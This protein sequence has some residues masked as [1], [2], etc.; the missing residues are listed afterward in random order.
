M[1]RFYKLLGFSGAA[2]I[3][4][5]VV[6]LFGYSPLPAAAGIASGLVAIG[7]FFA[8]IDQTMNE[9]HGLTSR[10]LMKGTVYV[11]IY[12]I[13]LTILI[14]NFLHLN[15]TEAIGA[16]TVAAEGL[17]FIGLS[18]VELTILKANR[19]LMPPKSPF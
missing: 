10:R 13:I 11:V 2:A 8:Y 17:G 7:F 16:F 4:I 14:I 5:G 12:V 3:T 1:R 6:E 15:A 18:L 9:V 19:R